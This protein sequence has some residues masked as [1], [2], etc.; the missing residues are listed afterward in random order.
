MPG[1]KLPILTIT[2]KEYFRDDGLYIYSSADGQLDL[3]ADT[4]AKITAPTV[5]LEATTITMDGDLSFDTGHYLT[6]SNDSTVASGLN[7][8][9]LISG[10]VMVSSATGWVTCK[11]GSTTGY[12]PVFS[13]S[14]IKT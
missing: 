7:G 5:E 8:N 11:I 1:A 12:I 2:N 3:I 10:G 14:R 4:T 13:S 6:F 9:A